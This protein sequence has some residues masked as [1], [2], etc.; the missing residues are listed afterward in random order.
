MNLLPYE[1]ATLSDSYGFGTTGAGWT[2]TAE[3]LVLAFTAAWL[4]PTIA[5]RDKRALTV[6]GVLVSSTGAVAS[7]LAQ[8]GILVVSSRLTVGLGCGMIAAATSALP[9]LHRRPK[10]V[11]GYMQVTLGIQFGFANYAMGLAAPLGRERLFV[12]ELA[13]LAL[14]GTLAMLLPRGVM[15]VSPRAA[16]AIVDSGMSKP[17]LACIASLVL[18]WASI[19]ASWSFAEQAATA[20]GLSEQSLILWFTISGLTGPGGGAI[21]AALG[22]RYGYVA[23][24]AV[25]FLIQMLSAIAMYCVGGYDTYVLGI[26]LFNA[27]VAFTTTY[28]MGLLAALDETGR[29][30]SMG[31]AAANFG[32]AVGPVLGV[33]ALTIP[34]LASVGVA[35]VVLLLIGLILCLWSAQT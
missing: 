5:R 16:G 9:T 17:V 30:A 7:I 21:A 19:E 35:A 28:L 29:G 23:P 1:V 6:A 25:G 15:K 4:G 26:M 27:P 12:V 8:E 3:L 13:F 22:E 24:L 18:L 34:N 20:R 11:F 31:A 14:L 33:V 10:R 2:A 32:G